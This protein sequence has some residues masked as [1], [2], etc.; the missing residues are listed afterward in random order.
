MQ[1]RLVE[2]HAA[3]RHHQLGS[4]LFHPKGE[5]QD[6]WQASWRLLAFEQLDSSQDFK[7][8]FESLVI[9]TKIELLEHGFTPTMLDRE[10]CKHHCLF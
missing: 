2:I 4:L 7:F 6:L 9:I 5:T 10:S 1:P 3:M 8:A